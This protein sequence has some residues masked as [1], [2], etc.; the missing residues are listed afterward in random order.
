MQPHIA[1]THRAE[2]ANATDDDAIHADNGAPPVPLDSG[3][4]KVERAETQGDKVM[5]P[6][7]KK[8]KSKGTPTSGMH[9]VSVLTG[10]QYI[11]F[12][13]YLGCSFRFDG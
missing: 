1:A 10:V 11:C 2:R 6:S 3:D 5:P 12:A 13:C 4:D 9:D 8:V 7:R